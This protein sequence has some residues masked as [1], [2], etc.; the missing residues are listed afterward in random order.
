MRVLTALLV[1]GVTL[2]G[3]SSPI[4]MYNAR[5]RVPK[6]VENPDAFSGS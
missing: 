4:Y 5:G 6:L 1:V 2:M 3:C